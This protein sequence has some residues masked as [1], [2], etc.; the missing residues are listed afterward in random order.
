MPIQAIR[1]VGGRF[2]DRVEIVK[3]GGDADVLT[4][5]D[6]TLS[7]ALPTPEEAALLAGADR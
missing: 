4:F 1:I 6:Q 2:V 5:T 7:D 3:D